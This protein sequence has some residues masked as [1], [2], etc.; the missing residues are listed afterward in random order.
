[1][2]SDNKFWSYTYTASSSA[3]ENTI[4]DAATG[5][6]YYRPYHAYYSS[7]PC[8]TIVT[9]ESDMWSELRSSGP[10]VQTFY[11]YRYGGTVHYVVVPHRYSGIT[12]TGIYGKSGRGDDDSYI[13]RYVTLQNIT[14]V[15]SD[16]TWYTGKAATCTTDGYKYQ[17]CASCGQEA[18]RTTIPKL[19]HSYS[20][21]WSTSATQ[22]WH[23]CTRCGNSSKSNLANHSFGGYYGSTATCTA[24]GTRYRKCS[25]CGYVESSTAPALG[26]AWPSSYTQNGGYLYKNCTRCKA[27]L[28]K[29]A[30]TYSVAFNGN[31]A[32]SGSM[33]N[34]SFT[35]DTAQNLNANTFT[36]T[37]YAF[38]GW[39]TN[40][41]A[42]SPTYT[43][44]QSVK[45]LT[46][47]NNG[48]VTLYAIWKLSTTTIAFHDNDGSNGPGSVTWLIGST[49]VP[50]SPIRQGY[51]FAGWTTNADGSGLSWPASNIVPANVPDYYAQW[52]PNIYTTTLEQNIQ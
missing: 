28:E 6:T 17:K 8:N 26:H 32:T 23:V 5:R 24:S 13:M 21:A 52:I 11:S 39:S 25:T 30:I 45:N 27:Q 49:Q 12:F 31:N 22:H 3:Y 43:N 44:Q 38:L 9:E 41:D 35:Y 42:T 46:T 29:K 18:N 36:R 51:N 33:S 10:T 14:P 34:Q 15:I 1:M 48:T 19:G 16:A 37:N 7:V 47:T 50:K 2:T 40:K 20:S 4:Y